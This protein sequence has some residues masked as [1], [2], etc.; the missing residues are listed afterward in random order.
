MLVL[1]REGDNWKTILYW[2]L[3]D[4]TIIELIRSSS[5]TEMALL[6]FIFTAATFQFQISVE[7]TLNIFPLYSLLYLNILFE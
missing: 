3:N 4:Y 5:V 6:Y 2:Q 7:I 1:D